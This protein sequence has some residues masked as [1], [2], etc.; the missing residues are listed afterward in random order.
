MGLHLWYAGSSVRD[1]PIHRIGYD[2]SRVDQVC[3]KQ[4]PAVAAIQFGHLHCVTHGVGPEEEPGHVVNG[5]A[6]RTFQI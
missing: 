6:F 3:V 2:G 5:N 1:S 4:D